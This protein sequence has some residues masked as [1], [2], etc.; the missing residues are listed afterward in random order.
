MEKQNRLLLWALVV[1]PLIAAILSIIP[2]QKRLKGGIDLVG[3]FSLLYEIDTTGLDPRDIRGLSTRVKDILQRRVDPNAQLNLVWRPVG[4]TR[5]EI[6]MPR[7]PQAA[8][9]RRQRYE[10]ALDRVEEMNVGR[11]EVEAALA[12]D[13]PGEQLSQL[14]RGVQERE[15]RFTELV[16]AYAEYQKT[17]GGDDLDAEEVA[18]T[19]YEEVFDAVLDTTLNP[20]RLTDV[21]ALQNPQERSEQIGRLKAA[22]PSYAAAIDEVVAKHDDWA[23]DKAALEDPSDLKRLIRG[24]G[25]LEFRILADRD[26][27]N[28]T[29][30]GSSEAS[31]RQPISKYTEQLEERGPRPTSADKYRWFP[32]DNVTAFLNVDSEDQVEGRAADGQQIVAEYAGTWYALAHAESRFGLLKDARQKWKLKS[33]LPDRDE[34]GRPAVSFTLDPAGGSQFARLTGDNV[35]RQLCI[36][37]DDSAM[38]QATIRERI[39][40]RGQ[41]SGRFSQEDVTNLVKTLDAGS[42]PGRLKE[43]PLMEKNVGPSLG[44]TNREMGMKAALYGLVA[45][46]VFILVYYR[47]AGLVANLALM[48]NLL[49][50]LAIMASLQATFTLPGIAGLILTVGMAVDANVLIFERIREERER[51]VLMKRALKTGYDKALSTIVDANLTTLITCVVLGYV[52]SEEVKGFAM[53]LG[54]GIVTSMFTALFV[55]RLIFSTLIDVGWLSDLKMFRLIVPPRIDWLSLRS[56]FWPV[57]MVMAVG[58]MCLFVLASARDKEKV[59]DIEF[60]GGTSVQIELKKGVQL[61]DE[62]VRLRLTAREL[63]GGVT[64][65]QWL[66]EASDALE[67]TTV[68]ASKHRAGQFVMTSDSLN[69]AQLAAL[70]QT[71]RKG[72]KSA[73][74]D[75]LEVGGVSGEGNTCRFDTK[76]IQVRV[77]D[78]ED[79]DSARDVASERSMTLEEFQEAVAAAA[80]YARRAA[81]LLASARVQEVEDLEAGVEGAPSS[82]AYEIV[83]VESNRQLVQ[84]AIL[85]ALGDDLA[86]QRP[87]NFTLVTDGDHPEGLYPIE[88]EDRYLSDVIGGEAGFNVQGFKGGVVLVF[89]DLE[90]AQPVEEIKR[91]IR[92][93]RLQPGFEQ[94]KWREYSVLGLQGAGEGEEQ[95]PIFSSVALL[96]VDEDLPYYDDPDRWREAVARPELTAATEALRAEKALRKVTQFAPQVAEQTKTQAILAVGVALAAIVA[97]VWLRFGQM[98]FGLA[99]IVALVHDVAITLGFITV[100]DYFH[101]GMIGRLLLIQDFRIDLPMIAAM[102]TIIGYSLN[103]TIV[104]F[105]RIRENRG[106]LTTLSPQMINASINQTLS[107]TVLTSLTTFVVVAIMYF[108]GGPGVHGFAYALLL[109]V[110]VGTYSSVGVASP[111]LY[112]PRLLHIVVYILVALGLFGATWVIAGEHTTVQVV[113]GIL[114]A[115]VLSWLIRTELRSDRDYGRLVSGTA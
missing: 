6:Q 24:A 70:M 65:A 113:V 62:D 115:A 52:G 114:L 109:G 75:L 48:M 17:R 104:V 7:P 18:R 16:A 72:E 68:E 90:P 36:F 106:K 27:S 82:H 22:H 103:D 54:F 108:L 91:R 99:A 45:V 80:D 59:Y 102:L 81:D 44:R 32:I 107:R 77:Q 37:L 20:G 67:Q 61:E 51:G 79:E 10:T 49:F 33:A 92:E 57:A 76:A 105:D 100:C 73:L 21:L 86:I 12:A 66:R 8:I 34:N 89:E 78:E 110:I 53:V 30:I 40:Q 101:G 2:P 23:A 84:E 87:I 98:Q 55:T 69:S 83:T 71:K 46:A 13:D 5:L 112:R 56:R 9:D 93:I 47:F 58:G 88:A 39:R 15:A 95:E 63:E 42:L 111:L 4:N 96:V 41:I 28:P 38:S 31:L 29:M 14:V 25:V 3:G 50:V 43:T 64:A 97:Y 74:V 26:A 94:Y 11:L 35:G 19:G 60:L 1:V 85:A